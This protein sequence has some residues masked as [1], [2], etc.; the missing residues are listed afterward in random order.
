MN[1]LA[2]R[3]KLSFFPRLVS[4]S[5][6]NTPPS[7]PPPTPVH[8]AMDVY[9]PFAAERSKLTADSWWGAA[10]DRQTV[11]ATGRRRRGSRGIWI[12]REFQNKTAARGQRRGNRAQPIGRPGRGHR[13]TDGHASHSA[14]PK[15]PTTIFFFPVLF[16]PRLPWTG[17]RR[18]N[19]LYYIYSGDNCLFFLYYIYSAAS[20]CIHCVSTSDRERQ[21]YLYIIPI[22]LYYVL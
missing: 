3:L 21:S 11:I 6:R 1:S 5:D 18:Y 9:E 14:R 22:Y 20:L 13:T 17:H 7:P 19:I 2:I 16:S 10:D 12:L 15:D 4:A 8:D